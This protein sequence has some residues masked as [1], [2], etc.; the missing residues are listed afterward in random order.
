MSPPA[1][2]REYFQ[3]LRVLPA[4]GH[5]ASRHPSIWTRSSRVRRRA[6]LAPPPWPCRLSPGSLQSR[7]PP[8]AWRRATAAPVSSPPPAAPSPAPTA[9][10]TSSSRRPPPYSTPARAALPSFPKAELRREV[11][12][13]SAP[14][15][16]YWSSM[17]LLTRTVLL[18]P[19]RR[20]PTVS[21][22]DVG[23][24]RRRAPCPPR[25]SR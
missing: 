25:T 19:M 24:W 12:N 13:G 16:A 8:P 15:S 22:Q 20:S 2:P 9:P 1:F 21:H 11:Q 23:R 10:E 4:S 14:P 18:T 7:K 6:P 3:S 17:L 5:P